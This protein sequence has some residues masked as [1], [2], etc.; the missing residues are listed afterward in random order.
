MLYPLPAIKALFEASAVIQGWMENRYPDKSLKV[1]IGHRGKVA[2]NEFPYISIALKEENLQLDYSRN[3]GLS[4][5][6]GVNHAEITNDENIGIARICEL[7]ELLIEELASRA[8]LT[9]PYLVQWEGEAI[10]RTDYG[11]Q[12]PFYEAETTLTLRAYEQEA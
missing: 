12:H 1:F 6:Y 11:V 3:V 7:G 4:I 9:S 5:M 8:I 10:T 2:A